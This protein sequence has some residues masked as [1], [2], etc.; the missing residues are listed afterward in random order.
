MYRQPIDRVVFRVL[1]NIT[2]K[3]WTYRK[4][5]KTNIMGYIPICLKYIVGLVQKGCNWHCHFFQGGE[6]KKL[7]NFYVK[8]QSTYNFSNVSLKALCF[9]M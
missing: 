7:F 4:G 3:E 1:F 2:K 6:K 9:T 8:S 5:M